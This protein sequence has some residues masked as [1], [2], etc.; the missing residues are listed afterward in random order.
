MKDGIRY[1]AIASGP[2]EKEKDSILVGVVFRNNYIEGL[3][4]STVKSDGTDSTDKIIRMI[5]H[6][7]FKDQ[8][9]VLLFNGIALAGLNIIDPEALEERLGSKVVLLNRRRQNPKELIN[10]LRVFSRLSGVK[11]EG[12]INIV[13]KSSSMRPVLVDGF[14]FQSALSEP[15]LKR[16]GKNAFEALRVAHI[17]ARGMATGES[18]GRL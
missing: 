1:I 4:S 14:Y 18:K 17:M 8:I 5:R 12:R 13:K 16:F 6:S 3:V 2:K 9:R 15:F 10:A 11:T 7:K